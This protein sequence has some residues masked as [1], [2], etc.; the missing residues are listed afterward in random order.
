MNHEAALYHYGVL[1]MHWGVRRY[2]NP[3][4]S[5]TAAG[6]KR[7]R[8]AQYK[9]DKYERSQLGSLATMS[10]KTYRNASK[11]YSKAEARFKKSKSDKAYAKM[12][13][14]AAVKDFWKSRS[15]S[16]KQK[17]MKHVDNMVKQYGSKKVKDV[18]FKQDKYSGT[19]RVK[20]GVWT[21]A[22]LMSLLGEIPY[23]PMALV[24]PTYNMYHGRTPVL[25]LPIV[26]RVQ[27]RIK[28]EEQ[29]GFDRRSNVRAYKD[30][31]KYGRELR[32]TRYAYN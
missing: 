17:L 4:G 19:N 26:K 31:K 5:L 15:E 24:M 16:D 10:G 32:R 11:K 28:A 14:A 12:R 29:A 27:G 21:K 25:T 20:E 3:D 7:Y 23:T 30:K 2:Q 1:G 8:K 9:R 22:D 18:K 6:E 13:D